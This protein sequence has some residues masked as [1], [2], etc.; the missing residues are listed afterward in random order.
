MLVL[1]S[2]DLFQDTARVWGRIL[3]F[4]GVAAMPLPMTLPRANAG[5]GEADAVPEAIRDDLRNALKPTATG[6]RAR[7]GFGWDWA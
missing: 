7:Y 5:R 2:E 3:R 1:R 4:L 6:V